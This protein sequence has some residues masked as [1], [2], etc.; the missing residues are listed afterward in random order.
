M[1]ACWAENP[2]EDYFKKHLARIL[3][4]IWV[5]E[6]GITMQVRIYTSPIT[7]LPSNYRN[8]IR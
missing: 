5:A 3:D 6:D 1:L 4:Y 2:T 7:N 8:I